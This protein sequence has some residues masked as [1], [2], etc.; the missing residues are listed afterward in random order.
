M[1]RAPR[2]RISGLVA[3][4]PA[5]VQENVPRARAIHW[6]TLIE[7]SRPFR[8]HRDRRNDLRAHGEG[9]LSLGSRCDRREELRHAHN[10]ARV[11]DPSRGTRNHGSGYTMLDSSPPR[12]FGARQHDRRGRGAGA[13]RED[14]PHAHRVLRGYVRSSGHAREYGV[15]ESYDRISF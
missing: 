9:D 11:C 5:R 12:R 7:L 15:H 4:P 6:G 13:L 14:S 2:L 8:A 1:A 3:S 10:P